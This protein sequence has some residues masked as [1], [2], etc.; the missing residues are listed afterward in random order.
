MPGPAVQVV[1][2]AELRKELRRLEDP[3]GWGRDL[4]KVNRT[5]AR[6]LAPKAQA[7][8]SAI[9]GQTGH[10]AKAIRGYGS[11]TG[12]RLGIASAGKGQRN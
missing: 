4:S 12:A 8:A 11:V 7:S 6:E 1:G 5:L 9:G 3:K 2:L 10:F